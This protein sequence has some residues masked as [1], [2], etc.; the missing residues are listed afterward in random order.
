MRGK[1]GINKYNEGFIGLHGKLL[2]YL[3]GE[4]SKGYSVYKC[5]Q[6]YR[7]SYREY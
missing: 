6:H 5:I 4:R 1:D 3:K 7:S 2:I